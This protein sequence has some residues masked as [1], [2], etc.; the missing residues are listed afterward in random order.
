M[1]EACQIML[2][3]MGSACPAVAGGDQTHWGTGMTGAVIGCCDGLIK[4]AKVGAA[5]TRGERE[6]ERLNW[7]RNV[8]RIEVWSNAGGLAA[9]AEGKSPGCT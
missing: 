1:R 4:P 3:T 6:P 5:A 8:A 2:R 7:S 9:E